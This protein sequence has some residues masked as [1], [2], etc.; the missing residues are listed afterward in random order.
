MLKYSPP[1][2]SCKQNI[3]KN[4]ILFFFVI[5]LMNNSLKVFAESYTIQSKISGGN[6]D[7][8]DTW[9]ENRLP[10]EDDIVKIDGVVLLNVDSIISG[11]VISSEGKLF[12]KLFDKTITIN[13]N[14]VNNG[15]IMDND[16][17]YD[18][19]VTIKTSGDI[20]NNG[21]W[22]NSNTFIIGNLAN[23][24]TWN[25]NTS[26]GGNNQII[27]NQDTFLGGIIL[28]NNNITFHDPL[29]ITLTSM[30]GI[31][32]IY[33]KGNNISVS[34]SVSGSIT[35]NANII[36]SGHN[37][38]ISS[39]IITAESITFAITG[40]KLFAKNTIINGSVIIEKNNIIS[41]KLFDRTI[42]VNGNIVNNGIIMDNDDKNDYEVTIKTSGD[43]TNNGKWLNSNTFI[44]GNLAN[45]GTWNSNTSFGG[46]NQIIS[47]QDTF[48]GG[49]ILNNN[50]ITFHDPL[51]ITLTSM[52]GIGYIYGKGN[53]ISV[54]Q[55]VSGSITTNA[56]IILSGHNQ[57]ISSDIITAESITFAITGTKLFAKNT[58][59]N[60][61]VIIEKNNII[62]NKL[63]DRTI[64]INGNIVN[65]GIIMDNDDKYDYGLTLRISGNITNN[66]TW[67]NYSTE[68]IWCYSLNV[69]KYELQFN[70][71]E[72]WQDPITLTTPFYNISTV[73][74]D[75]KYW[76]V[77]TYYNN[78][79][80]EFL[81]VK[82]INANKSIKYKLLI[83]LDNYNIPL[84]NTSIRISKVDIQTITDN[85]GFFLLS[86]LPNDTYTIAI[87]TEGLNYETQIQID[88]NQEQ[89][90]NV[91]VKLPLWLESLIKINIIQKFDIHSDNIIG[92]EEAI[93]ALNCA[94]NIDHN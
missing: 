6:W 23:Y 2:N 90:N 85:E 78:N 53:N 69:L 58:I 27:S 34:Q 74:Y 84:P 66:G 22:L 56:N 50:N 18:Y 63:F 72:I 76:R 92:L 57:I 62:S 86:D 52:D 59:I 47:N 77:K 40:T 12:N 31:G 10:N 87:Q 61:S 1:K 80:F 49:I 38:I 28:N 3:S 44:I 91:F 29:P 65:N 73:I 71:N 81:D 93:H 37:Q 88:E 33:G 82:F 7:D 39:D 89:R 25:S 16:D 19:E 26:F 32:Y 24:G 9:I 75:T 46:N 68:I 54:S 35:T 83:S 4:I 20:T 17:K 48:L 43:I 13:G 15:I 21:K 67:K 8:I 51:P 41:N 70:E 5:L 60:G 79:E 64:T 11:L 30:D 42:T 14:I 55:S 94:S 45:Y 36:L